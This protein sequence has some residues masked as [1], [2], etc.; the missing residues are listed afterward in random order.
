MGAVGW[1]RGCW[2]RLRRLGESSA[3]AITEYALLVALVALA[4]IAVVAVFG[5][6]ISTWFGTKTGNITTV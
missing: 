6:N 2:I 3:L 4:V 1:L 5:P